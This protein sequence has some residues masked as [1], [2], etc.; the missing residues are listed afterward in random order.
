MNAGPR[1][2]GTA[3]IKY[4]HLIGSLDGHQGAWGYVRGGMGS[5]A[6]ALAGFA[7]ER[8]VEI[9]TGA[10]VAEVEVQEGLLGAFAST[11]AV[12]SAPTSSCRTPT[13]TAPT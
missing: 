3:Y 1:T 12:A 6:H 5:I 10:E 4:H 2:L 11:T 8:G 7:H 9:I 13:R